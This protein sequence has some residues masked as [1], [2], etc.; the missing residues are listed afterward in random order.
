MLCNNIEINE[1]KIMSDHSHM[2]FNASPNI[3]QLDPGEV[4]MRERVIHLLESKN[5]LNSEGCRTSYHKGQGYFV[6][7]FSINK[8]LNLRYFQYQTKEQRQKKQENT[9]LK[10]C[11]FK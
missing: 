9:L 3:V 1:M 10:G 2:N 4:V 5:H 7:T 11:V 6:S 8:E